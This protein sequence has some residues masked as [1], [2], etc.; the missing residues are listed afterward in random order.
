MQA[1][2][3]VLVTWGKFK[4]TVLK[5]ADS[6]TRNTAMQVALIDGNTVRRYLNSGGPAYLRQVFQEKARRNAAIKRGQPVSELTE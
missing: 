5:F 3:I 4:T 6:V 2:M 1:Q